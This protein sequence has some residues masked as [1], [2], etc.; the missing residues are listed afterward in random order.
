MAIQPSITAF[1][2]SS[3]PITGRAILMDEARKGVRN[4]ASTA[5][6][7]AMRWVVRLLGAGFSE[8]L[9]VAEDKGR[10]RVCQW[11]PVRL[12]A[13]L[14]CVHNVYSDVGE[15]LGCIDNY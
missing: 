15:L 5:V 7:S 6:T 10:A 8:S 1:S 11:E 2:E 14:I 9:I 4:E 12:N 13:A 3:A